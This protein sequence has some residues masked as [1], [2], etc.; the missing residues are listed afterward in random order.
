MGWLLLVALVVAAAVGLR[1]WIVADRTRDAARRIATAERLAERGMAVRAEAPFPAELPDLPLVPRRGRPRVAVEIDLDGAT[2]W[3]FEHRVYRRPPLGR[4]VEIDNPGDNESHTSR[5]TVACLRDRRLDL[6]PMEILPAL[7]CRAR[8]AVAEG[9]EKWQARPVEPGGARP[10]ATGGAGVA[11]LLDG[12]LVTA[13]RVHDP[14]TAVVWGE[15]EDFADAYRVLSEDAEGVPSVLS[16]RVVDWLL[17]R[18][19]A[20]VCAAGEWLLLSRNVRWALVTGDDDLP[21]G[22]LPPD[23]A[24]ELGAG[25]TEL[26]ALLRREPAG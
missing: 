2:L 7:L 3:V 26:A 22:W 5:H 1:R 21:L 8:T 24:A 4:N 20:I 9:F 23:E 13:E 16:D 10:D 12:L 25:V 18:P 11:R 15:R 6:P 14:R 19:G 17:S